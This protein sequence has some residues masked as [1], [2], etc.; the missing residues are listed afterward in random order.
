MDIFSIIPIEAA[1]DSRLSKNH[2]RVLIALLSFRSKSTNVV[3]PSRELLSERCGLPITRISEI[4]SSLCQLGWLEKTGKGGFSKSTRYT[5]TVPNVIKTTVTEPVTVT[6][7]VTVTEPVT[8]TVTESVTITVT[9]TVT[10]K[11]QTIEQTIEQTNNIRAKKAATKPE[12]PEDV[13][14]QIWNDFMVVRKAKK[15]PITETAIKHLRKEA[16]KAGVTLSYAIQECVTR[17]WQSFKASWF[18][19]KKGRTIA[20]EE[21]AQRRL[22]EWLGEGGSIEGEVIK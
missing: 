5:V 4:T 3:W 21:E 17:G 14:D 16:E 19:D 11:E 2:Y 20:D 8:S 12:K 1:M 10:G 6:D 15:A 7:L 22:D 18:A 13:D 9:E